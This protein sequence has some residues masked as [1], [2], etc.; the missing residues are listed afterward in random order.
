MGRIL[1]KLSGD[2]NTFPLIEVMVVVACIGILV[3][4][5]VQRLLAH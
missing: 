3:T 5:A 4:I 2:D 1:S